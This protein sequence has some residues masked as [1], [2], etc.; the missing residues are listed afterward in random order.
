VRLGI[1]TAARILLFSD[2]NM[3][4]EGGFREI[5]ATGQWGL[6]A[7]IKH[8]VWHAFWASILTGLKE[9][10]ALELLDHSKVRLY[11]AQPRIRATY[12]ALAGAVPC[13]ACALGMPP[14]CRVMHVRCA[15]PRRAGSCMCVVL[16]PAVPGHACALCSRDADLEGTVLRDV[17]LSMAAQGLSILVLIADQGAAL[18]HAC[19]AHCRLVQRR[20]DA[21]LK[22]RAVRRA[23]TCGQRLRQL[24][25]STLMYAPEMWMAFCGEW[26]ACDCR[27]SSGEGRATRAACARTCWCGG[28]D[29]AP[30]MG[31]DSETPSRRRLC[32]GCCGGCGGGGVSTLEIDA[33]P[34]CCRCQCDCGLCC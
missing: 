20:K 9:E 14:P 30:L 6:R 29:G 11:C 25:D 23:P 32:G 4:I 16:A 18:L 22:T 8:R 2:S 15:R 27:R 10:G 12:K 17:W 19:I 7:E 21:G 5:V 1:S 33:A 3:R 34:P 13:H 28:R 24:C 26:A 31:G